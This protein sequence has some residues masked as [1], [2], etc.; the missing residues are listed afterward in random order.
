MVIEVQLGWIKNAGPKQESMAK[1]TIDSI[2]YALN[3]PDFKSLLLSRKFRELKFQPP[4]GELLSLTPEEAYEKLQ[5]GAELGGTKDG[6]ITIKVRLANTRSVGYW[7]PGDD[8]FTTSYRTINRS[9][10]SGSNSGLAANFIHEWCHVAG[11]R[12]YP[13]N[14]ARDDMAYHTGSIVSRLI[15]ARSAS[16]LNKSFEIGSNIDFPE[17]QDFMQCGAEAPQDELPAEDDMI[18]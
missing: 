10:S 5:D 17:I 8:Y 15:T 18:I 7:N 2:R 6:V 16:G 11:F 1:R 14:S 13:N 4:G 9:I 12:H 3:H